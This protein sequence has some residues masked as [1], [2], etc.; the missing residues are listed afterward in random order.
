MK[1]KAISLYYITNHRIVIQLYYDFPSHLTVNF[2]LVA[3]S[4][5]SMVTIYLPTKY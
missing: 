4:E 3:G 1:S 2:A 5:I